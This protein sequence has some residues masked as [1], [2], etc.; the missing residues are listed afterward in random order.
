MLILT[1]KLQELIA[2][3]KT[4]DDLPPEAL[5]DL[6]GELETLKARLWLRLTTPNGHVQSVPPADRTLN[7]EEAAAMLGHSSDWLYRHAHKFPFACR[8][9]GR[10]TFSEE[11]IKKYKKY[12]GQRTGQ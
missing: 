12:L 3:P 11:G 1:W 7:V 10:W 5:P 6:L 4:V 2:D 8:I 9:E